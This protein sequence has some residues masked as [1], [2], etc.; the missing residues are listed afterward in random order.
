MDMKKIREELLSQIDKHGIMMFSDTDKLNRASTASNTYIFSNKNNQYILDPAFGAKRRREISKVLSKDDRFDVLCT[1][2]HNDHSANNGQ[3]AGKHSHIYY[4]YGIKKKIRYF[5]TNSTG[6]IV[7]MAKYL[8][9]HGMLKRFKMFPN[10]L[11]SLIVFSSKISRVFPFAFLF[12]VSYIY[13]WQS[14]GQINSG[15]KKAKYFELANIEK[16]SLGGIEID[17][18]HIDDN[19][20]AIDTQGHTDDHLIY[21]LTDKKI[22]FAGDTL[23]FLNGNDIQFGEIDKVD[24]TIHILLEFIEKEKV[25]ILLQGH[26]YPVTGT[27]NIMAYVSDIRD[28][29]NEMYEIT[30]SVI[31][32]MEG[33]ITFDKALH[34]L[35]E[36]PAELSQS[37]KKITFPRSTLVFLD[38]YLLKVL[39]SLGYEKQKNGKWV[40]NTI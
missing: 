8:D 28:K 40:N 7:T 4:H 19:L 30:S 6:Q 11:I 37:L 16:I 17:G 32:S 39:Q 29:H 5:R 38:V 23:N 14:I 26:Y 3:I 10:W 35:Y 33:P 18:W 24:E 2:Y 34:K 25:T 9:L 20:I 22:L 31:R 27:D 15:R 1:H 21:Y 13:S 36:H 12:F